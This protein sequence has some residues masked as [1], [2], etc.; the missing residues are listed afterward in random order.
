MN[1]T[2]PLVNFVFKRLV[3]ILCCVDD[4]QWSKFPPKGP[5]LL[6][7]NHINFLEVPVMYLHLLPRPITGF[8]KAENWEKPFFRW[9]FN[10]WGGIPLHRAEADMAAMR[11]GLAALAEGKILTVAPEGTRTGDGRLIR[12]H[13]GIVLMALKADTPILPVAYCG[14]EHFWDNIRRLRRT[15]FNVRVGRPFRLEPGSAPV[16]KA[17]RQQMADEIM[18]QIARLLPPENRGYYADLSAATETY[19]DF[20][21]E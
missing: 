5:L 16:T 13:P 2:Y 14:S 6:A 10:L 12:G 19:L 4:S 11:A 21:P 8:V 3:R 18:Y 9:L 17:V 15:P 1:V 20:L 7:A